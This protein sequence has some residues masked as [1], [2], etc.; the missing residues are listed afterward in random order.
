MTQVL[1]GIMV[2]LFILGIVGTGWAEQ[3]GVPSLADS[4]RAWTY[5]TNGTNR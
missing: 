1:H 3:T 2:C 4:V 5:H